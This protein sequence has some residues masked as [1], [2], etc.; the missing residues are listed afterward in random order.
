MLA[1]LG[2]SVADAGISRR[3]GGR[4]KGYR[5]SEETKAKLRAAW[6]RRR[7]ARARS[8]ESS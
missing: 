3:R 2:H 8:S 5:M 7:A 1:D 4:P 6:K